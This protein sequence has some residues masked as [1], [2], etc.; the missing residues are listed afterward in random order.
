MKPKT[1]VKPKHAPLLSHFLNAYET[2]RR[3]MDPPCQKPLLSLAP[4]TFCKWYQTALAP[5]TILSPA[6]ICGLDFDDEEKGI[7]HAYLLQLVSE[8]K[9]QENGCISPYRFTLQYYSAEAHPLIDDLQKLIAFCTPDRAMDEEGLLLP[10]DQAV[11]LRRL[12]LQ[13]AFYLEYLT[14]L[15]WMQ[16]LLLPMPAIH[17]KRMQPAPEC[18]AFF[19]QSTCELLRQLAQTGCEVAAERFIATMDMDP[20]IA[21]PDFFL[22]ALEENKYTDHIFAALY[23]KVGID[24]DELWQVPPDVMNGEQRAIVSSFLFTG[25]MLDKWFLTP[26]SIFFHLI[27]SIYFTP[28]Q[29]YRVV[30]N[31]AALLMM[32][33]NVGMELFAPPAYYSRTPLGKALF[34]AER[35]KENQ[36]KMPAAVGFAE[37]LEAVAQ[38][39][40]MRE[41]ELLA[42]M[43]E[44]PDILS[45]RMF[46]NQDPSI[47][48]TIEV[49]EDMELHSFCCNLSALFHPE[50]D[51]DYL[52]AVPDEN[53]FP[54]EYSSTGSKRSINKTPGRF[55][56]ELSLSAGDLLTLY[57][58][59]NKSI[60]YSLEILEKGK[61]NPY[62]IYPRISG[63]S[64]KIV[65]SEKFDETF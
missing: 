20:D 19:A 64:R 44:V 40:E 61:G 54:R 34:P 32:E 47:W 56:R 38:A 26:M 15:A 16:G 45:M 48:R 3:Q 25:V 27:R 49:Q 53:G 23:A 52:L 4:L 58:L 14:R 22:S 50:E 35:E 59:Q 36:Q 42:F 51:M 46:S 13:D 37:I 1:T 11:L 5:D 43:E 62:L 18:D 2:M 9:M 29:L 65:E 41:Q 17:T 33:R 10:E 12:S 21:T 24:M 28:M 63:Q 7:D 8:E 6:N 39:T 57:P 55:L 60:S 30:N 31:L